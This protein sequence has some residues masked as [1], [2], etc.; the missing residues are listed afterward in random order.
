[1]KKYFLF[2]A[3]GMYLQ[4]ALFADDA[5]ES[6]NLYRAQLAMSSTDYLVTAG[7]VYTLSFSANNTAVSYPILVDTSYRVR[8]ANITTINVEGN[9]FLRFKQRVEELVTQNYH[10][11]S[12]QFVLTS[13]AVF[14]V[15]VK[16]EVSQTAACEAWGLMRLSDVIKNNLTPYSSTRNV[17]ITSSNGIS[18]TYDLFQAERFG[19]LSQNPYMRPGDVVTIGRMSRKVTLDGAVER[20]GTYELLDGE[21]LQ[22]LIYYYGG[23][24]DSFADVSRIVLTRMLNPANPAG[25]KIYLDEKAVSSNYELLS[26]DS[27]NVSA[28]SELKPVMFIEGAIN[29]AEG[30]TLYASSRLVITFDEGENYS[31]LVSRLQTF[32]TAESDVSNAYVIRNGKVIPLNVGKMLYDAS[33]YSEETIKRYD[34]LVIP[35]KQYFVTVAGAVMNPGRYPY[36]PDRTWEYYIGLAGGFLLE[37]N[38]GRSV[39]IQ[40]ISGKKMRKTELITPETT[41]TAST[42]S[43]T[44]YFNQYAPVITTVLSA[45]STTVTILIATRSIRDK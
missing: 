11:S 40:D 39:K 10:M 22:Q 17:V 15:T 4:G 43:F 29:S 31:T 38:R 42:N 19:D 27:V 8:V 21:N 25:E 24:F 16:G 32:F 33:Y 13:P 2:I 1:M 5:Q 30:T 44:Y 20:K 23:G 12:V 14:Q 36:I 37:K 26:Y 41:I 9:T 28:Y 6:T 18:K 3:I 7:D 34:T 45:V 35:F